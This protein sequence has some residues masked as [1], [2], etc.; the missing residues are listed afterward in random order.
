MY[1]ISRAFGTRSGAKASPVSGWIA[2]WWITF[3][4]FHPGVFSSRP[5]MS[6]SCQ[7]VITIT[8]FGFFP[9]SRVLRSVLN[10][11]HSFAR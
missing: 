1:S 10:H 5:M 7:R 11:F 3:Q 6:S 4:S 2:S 8:I 9:V